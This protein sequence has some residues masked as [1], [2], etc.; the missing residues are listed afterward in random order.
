MVN[1]KGRKRRRRT[2][3]RSNGTD[4]VGGAERPTG[5][6]QPAAA[7]SRPC[8]SRSFSSY[9]VEQNSQVTSACLSVASTDSIS[10]RPIATMAAATRSRLQRQRSEEHTSEL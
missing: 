2:S 8:K 10:A 9:R 4:Q 5:S 3:E 7:S 1:G 6:R